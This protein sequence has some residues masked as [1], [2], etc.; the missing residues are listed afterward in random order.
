MN[1]AE[2]G[3]LEPRLANKLLNALGFAEL[4][5]ARTDGLIDGAEVAALELMLATKVVKVL[6]RS[7]GLIERV[8]IG[9]LAL[10]LPS[11]L[12]NPAGLLALRLGSTDGSSETA[13]EVWR[14][15]PTLAKKLDNAAGSLAL[16]L[17]TNVG[18]RDVM[19]AGATELK[20][21]SKLVKAL[22]F[23]ELRLARTDGGITGAQAG[24]Y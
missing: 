5:L 4:K 14:L 19:E 2:V 24:E 9:R 6:G 18:L 8:D 1:E 15:D 13:P 17:A 16:K 23:A 10:T 11:R 22:G 20:L 21:A 3:T 7:D 12:D